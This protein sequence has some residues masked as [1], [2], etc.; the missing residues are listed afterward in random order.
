MV[1]VAIFKEFIHNFFEV[2][3][4]D[5]IMFILLKDCVEVLILILD[6]YR[7]FQIALKIKN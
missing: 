1:V 3:L 4:E 2:Y 7:Q 5:W 6:R